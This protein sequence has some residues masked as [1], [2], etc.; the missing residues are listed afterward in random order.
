MKC[1]SDFFHSQMTREISITF[2]DNQHLVAAI[3]GLEP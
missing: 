3:E 2:D 1:F